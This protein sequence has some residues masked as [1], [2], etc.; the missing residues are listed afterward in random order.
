MKKK[1]VVL[2]L[3]GALLFSGLSVSAATSKCGHPAVSYYNG[4]ENS[5]LTCLEH[6]NCEL[7]ITYGVEYAT[8]HYCFETFETRRVVIKSEHK[9]K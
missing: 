7:H 6:T 3:A 2:G 9:N 5:V 8:C 1:L 4:T